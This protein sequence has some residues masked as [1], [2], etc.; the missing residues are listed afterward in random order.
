MYHSSE[1]DLPRA[2][3]A[4]MFRK[5]MLYLKKNFRVIPFSQ[6]RA[7]SQRPPGHYREGAPLY[8]LEIPLMAI[9]RESASTEVMIGRQ[10]FTGRTS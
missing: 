7:E 1:A 5:Q 9:L 6:L 3:P 4:A 10:A 2:M 8:P